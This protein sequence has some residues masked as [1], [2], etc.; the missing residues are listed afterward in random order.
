MKITFWGAAGEVTGSCY[1]VET[2]RVRVM[3][4]CGI[5]QGYPE[6]E[7]LN[8]RLPW[9]QT[10]H[11][12][13]IVLSHAHLDHSG[14]LPLLLPLPGNARIH[15]TPQTIALTDILLLD[16]ARLQQND[17]VHHN[18]RRQR[19]G[20]AP[21]APLYTVEQAAQVIARMNPIPYDQPTQVADGIAIRF[22]DAGHIIGSASI[23]MKVREGGTT[24]TIVF[25]A[26]IGVPGSPLL[27]DPTTLEHADVLLLESTYG[28]RDHRALPETLDAL[29][30][31][32]LEAERDQEKVL[33]PSFAVGRAQN[34]MYHIA[35]LHREGRIRALP[36]YL[37]SPMAIAA[38]NL[39]L[40]NTGI[41]DE[42]TLALVK[43][44]QD[45]LKVPGMSYCTSAEES[46][47]LNDVKGAMV[48]I[49]G[50]GMCNGGRIVH[51]LRHNL[52][53]Q[54]VHVVFVGF[55]GQ[56]TLG[57]HLINR[58]RTVRIFGEQ[59][60]VN[61][62]LHTLGGLSAHAGQ[63]TLV[64]WARPLAKDKPRVFLTH[65]EE[66]PR[67][68]LAD[69]LRKDLGMESTRPMRGQSFDL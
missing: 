27:R 42:E 31:I 56:G 48:I 66:T 53:R 24:K 52:W 8:R 37:D 10:M 39:Y 33:I 30:D 20:K 21:I 59:V 49:A 61:A 47:R 17:A 5:H 38:S 40:A 65:G 6:A 3:V 29:T 19:A 28:N 57:R 14:R 34:L 32:L 46:K 64:E 54:G 68:A 44:K 69:R 45:V 4:D 60:A 23:E 51:H 22:V 18:R 15:A 9:K 25:S 43:A 36:V 35:G 11:L 12:D 16:S 58:P 7:A 1:I 50:S 26:D 2:D 55:Q 67:M 41:M 63:S 13:A 62:Q